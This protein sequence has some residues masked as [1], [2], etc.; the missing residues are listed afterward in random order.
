MKAPAAICYQ[1]GHG[2]KCPWRIV[3]AGPGTVIQASCQQNGPQVANCR[4]EYTIDQIAWTAPAVIEG[5]CSNLEILNI[6]GLQLPAAPLIVY[7]TGKP[8]AGVPPANGCISLTRGL[9]AVAGEQSAPHW[10]TGRMLD[11]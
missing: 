5:I 2:G 8:A 9:L 4:H 7:L 10:S 6:K 11:R 1:Q 3:A